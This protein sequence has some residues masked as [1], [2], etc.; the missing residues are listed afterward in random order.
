MLVPLLVWL[1]VPI[2]TTIGLSQ[3]IQLPIAAL[4]TAGNVAFGM[5][6]I[7]LGAVL[8]V[9]LLVGS[10]V[11]ARAAHVLPSRT[12]TRLVGLLMLAVGALIILRATGVLGS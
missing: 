11:G 4:A 12:L 10:I 5:L 7:R 2:L 8:A 3:V 6:D 1:K 9:A